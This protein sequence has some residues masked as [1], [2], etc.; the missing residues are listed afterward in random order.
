[1]K[2]SLKST[3]SI[4]ALC[5]SLSSQAALIQV[6]ATDV[7]PGAVSYLAPGA[8]DIGGFPTPYSPGS[9]LLEQTV[10]GSLDDI[11]IASRLDISALDRTTDNGDE[12]SGWDLALLEWFTEFYYYNTVADE[13][14]AVTSW[15]AFVAWDDVENWQTDPTISGI[16]FWSGDVREFL[17]GN[18]WL[19]GDWLAVS[20]FEGDSS[21]F[22]Y[23]FFTV[24]DATSIPAPGT[25]ALFGLA[26]AGLGAS[27][28]KKL[29]NNAK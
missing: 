8:G 27:R 10:F 1:M 23:N 14:Q 28:R 11:R 9:T 2:I 29:S 16:D 5:F 22:T 25:L 21:T 17:T 20:S 26:L 13:W 6:S 18:S 15:Y 4:A 3:L 12:A 24:S 7:L 19:S